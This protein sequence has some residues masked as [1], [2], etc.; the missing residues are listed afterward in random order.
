MTLNTKL[1]ADSQT[2]S[3]IMAYLYFISGTTFYFGSVINPILY[4]VVSNKYRRAFRDLFRCRLTYNPK[5]SNRNQR[6]FFQTNQQFN[7]N[8]MNYLNQHHP[9]QQQQQQQQRKLY[10]SNLSLNQNLELEHNRYHLNKNIHHPHPP[11][12][13][14]SSVIT[15]PTSTPENRD[16]CEPKRFSLRK[17]I[18]RRQQPTSNVP[19]LIK[20]NRT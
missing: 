19:W 3:K 6:K 16:K 11:A 18:L 7:H 15:S 1:N 17:H 14:N 9:Q 2:F 13:S 10:N 20:K 4:N 5:A 12:S 8:F